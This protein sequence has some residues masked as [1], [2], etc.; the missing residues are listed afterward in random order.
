MIGTALASALVASILT[1]VGEKSIEKVADGTV[2][3][4]VDQ[5][6]SVLEKKLKKGEFAVI[7]RAFE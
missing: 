4:A 6:R 5:S 3:Q 1:K 2:S 7:R